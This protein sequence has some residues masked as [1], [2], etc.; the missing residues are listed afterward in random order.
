MLN[1]FKKILDL[2]LYQFDY[3]NKDRQEYNHLKNLLK[4]IKPR[5]LLNKTIVF[6]TV[7]SYRIVIDREYFLGKLLALNG[8]KVYMLLDDTILHLWE[9]FQYNDLPTNQ[10]YEK[11]NFNPNTHRYKDFKLILQNF[12]RKR[13]NKKALKIYSDKDLQTIY[14]STI[15]KKNKVNIENWQELEKYAYSSTLRFFK[16]SLLDFNDKNVKH[17]YKIAY[18]NAV[19]SRSIGEYV[20]NELKPDLFITSHG[21]YSTWAP[22]YDYLFKKGLKTLV[23]SDVHGHSM[24]P[25]EI[26]F[27]NTK[28][29]FLS[30]S[31]FWQKFK[32]TTLTEKNRKDILKYFEN[33]INFK[34]ADSKMLYVGG[35]TSYK[36]DKNDGYKYHLAIFPKVVWDGNINDRHIIFKGFID[37]IMSTVNHLKNRKDVKLYIKAHPSEITEAKGS[38]KITDIVKK[39]ISLEN[40]DNIVLIPPE[41]R[42]N[43]YE[44]IKGIDVGIVYD[45]VL[46]MELPFL[47]IP[48]ITCVEGGMF[49][50]EN[51][52]IVP[53]DREEYF[54][55]LDHLEEFINKFNS[56]YAE[57]YENVLKYAYW[58]IFEN[59]VKLPTLSKKA[60]IKT[61]LMQLKKEDL[62]LDEKFLEL[63][64]Y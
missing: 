57:R 3:W 42:I 59:A 28:I 45:G 30:K 48:T 29:H 9:Y 32:S 64:E 16:T 31:A 63:I 27:S 15:I 61:D 35:V 50:I 62:V 51:G 44:F 7:R 53:K 33:R 60:Y 26:F 56:N 22:A 36:V 34:T 49:H 54:Y 13:I 55:F 25:R 46:G 41:M 38:P 43:T 8:A 52:N 11:F 47:K 4:D 10:N 20:L 18:K 12:L 40:I 39:L 17:Y 21:I 23:Y 1:I 5:Q 24:D 14:Y 2:S 58:Y 37:W 6:N 19:L